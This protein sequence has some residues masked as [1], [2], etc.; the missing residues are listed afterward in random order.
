MSSH[1][2]LLLALALAAAISAGGGLLVE[3]QARR[4]ETGSVL[5][6]LLGES[7]R[8]FA[9]HVFLKADA[10]FHPGFYT[11]VFDPPTTSA[12]KTHLV[13]ATEENH[14][15]EHNHGQPHNQHRD[16][17]ESFAS[18]FQPT[19]HRHLEGLG[20]ARE[21]LPWLRLAAELDPQRVETYTV[22]A[23][24]LRERLNQV[25]EAESF[26]REGLRANPDSYEILFE[27]G[28]LYAEN[29]RDVPR[30]RIVLEL[31]V[32]KWL[33]QEAS[34]A[35][36][37]HVSYRQILGQLAALEERASNLE[38]ALAHYFRVYQ[39]SPNPATVQ[40]RIEE[41]RAKLAAPQKTPP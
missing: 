15:H 11:S 39:V 24:W 4:R 3:E 29:D 33:R 10:Y 7:R 40:K 41:L 13:E 25:K 35:S 6:N 16:W 28:R 27:L 26:L 38:R 21:I 23:Y 37:D 22:T 19:E 5:K 8:A 1:P 31:A 32:E 17:I 18:H 20:Q 30:A 2:L 12:G 9:M 34:K 14:R 36:P